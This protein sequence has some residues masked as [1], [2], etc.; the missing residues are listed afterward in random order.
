MNKKGYLN[1][2]DL[3]TFV[4]IILFGGIFIFGM[5][6][7]Q[8]TLKHHK[9]DA[10]SAQ[11]ELE[12][13]HLDFLN[14]AVLVN[15]QK[16]PFYVLLDS[17]VKNNDFSLIERWVQEYFTAHNLEGKFAVVADFASPPSPQ[18]VR[19]GSAMVNEDILFQHYSANFLFTVKKS[20]VQ[21]KN[22][23]TQFWL[24]DD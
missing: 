7:F 17:A 9:L 4:M 12:M 6:S 24:K 14:S 21:F 5:F 16:V 11:L 13:Q 3:I 19:D 23:R 18:G 8:L 22:Y 1:A 10:Q 2:M 20:E 15:S